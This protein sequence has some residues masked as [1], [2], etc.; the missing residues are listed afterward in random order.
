METKNQNDV[1]AT[2]TAGVTETAIKYNVELI[3]VGRD[4]HNEIFIVE[5]TDLEKVGQAILNRASNHLLSSNCWLAEAKGSTNKKGVFH[6]NA[7]Y[8]TVGKATVS[9]VVGGN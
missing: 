4:N 1:N 9:A 2:G 7:G 5:A 3:E 6:I 8:H